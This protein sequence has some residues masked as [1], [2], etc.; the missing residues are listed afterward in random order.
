[1]RNLGSEW[2]A[3]RPTVTCCEVDREG[4]H[5]GPPASKC[6]SSYCTPPRALGVVSLQSSAIFYL[7]VNTQFSTL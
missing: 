4:L 5:S 7:S 2:I 1:M 3:D 6:A